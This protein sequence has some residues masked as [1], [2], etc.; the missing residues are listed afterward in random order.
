MRIETKQRQKNI[1]LMV[2]CQISGWLTNMLNLFG[3]KNQGKTSA[4]YGIGTPNFLHLITNSRRS[5]NA[6]TRI[7][8]DGSTFCSPN[9]VKTSTF[10]FLSKSIF[11]WV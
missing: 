8:R 3:N 4:S 2:Q 7:T 1:S 6:I 9:E 10:S 5:Q 11:H